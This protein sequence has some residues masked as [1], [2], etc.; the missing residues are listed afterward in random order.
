VSGSGSDLA[1]HV[2]LRE[3]ALPADS[4]RGVLAVRAEQLDAARALL[5]VIGTR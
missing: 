1:P 4:E 2:L 3:Y 5:P